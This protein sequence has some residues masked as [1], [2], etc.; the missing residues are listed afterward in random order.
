[1]GEAGTL[2]PILVRTMSGVPVV[3]LGN[4]AYPLLQWLMKL[5][6]GLELSG[7]IRKFNTR[8]SRACEVV[9]C[10]FERTLEE[11]GLRCMMLFIAAC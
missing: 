4:P 11:T 1:M 3:I 5:Y 9:D 7:T 2:I 8:L 6:P 10:A